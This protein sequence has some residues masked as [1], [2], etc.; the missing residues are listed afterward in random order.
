[1]CQFALSA[2]GV[3]SIALSTTNPERVKE[4]ID[5]AYVKIPKEFWEQMKAK[6]LMSKD[7]SYL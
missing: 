7:Y 2:P 1:M 3:V 4:N 5:M 6:G